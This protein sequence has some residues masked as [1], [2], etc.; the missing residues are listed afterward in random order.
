MKLSIS[1]IAWLKAEDDTIYAFMKEFGYCGLEIA[2]TRIIE[3]EPYDAIDEAVSIAKEL[4]EKY[5]FSISSMQSILFGKT[6][7]LFGSEDERAHLLDYIYKAI[8]FAAAIQCSSLVFG[9]P[10]N[11]LLENSS[12]VRLAIPFFRAI[13][14]YAY[15]K[16]CIINIEANPAVY[17][18]NYIT[19]TAEALRLVR[20][21]DSLGFRINLDL[22][23]MLENNEKMDILSET[24][25]YVQHIHI[26]E[27]H[28]LPIRSRLEHE[29]LATE[30]L[31][32]HYNKYVSIEMKRDIE[33]PIGNVKRT[34]EYVARIFGGA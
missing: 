26:S 8:D 19:H 16:G 5:Q 22:G 25:Q 17:G 21:V 28:L 1:N 33:D 9:S 18:T 31:S 14:E 15:R 20:E 27:P 23:T 34:L 24:L 30:L 11:R 6:E 13:G 29:L 3:K 4:Y 2:P 7:R 12:D 10:K 32:N